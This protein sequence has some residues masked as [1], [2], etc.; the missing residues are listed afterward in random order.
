MSSDLDIRRTIEAGKRNLEAK[1]L[2]H[3][4]CRHA[5]VEKFGGTG[6]IEME[7]GLPI[8][9]HSMACD[10]APTSG[11]ATWFLEE[12][13]VY[14]HDANC[15][16]CTKR[17]PVALPNISKLIAQRDHDAELAKAHAEEEK[18]KIEA[19]FRERSKIRADIRA[20]SSVPATTFLDDLEAFDAERTV[21]NGHRLIESARLA[22]EMLTLEL[23]EHLFALLESG[24]HWFDE[25]GLTILSKHPFDQ[26]RLTHCAMQCLATGNVLHLAAE[27]V[28]E[29]MSDVS[30]SDVRNA[31]GGLAYVA[32]PP[33][34]EFPHHE[35]EKEN[36][37]P[38]TLIAAKFPED[39]AQGIDDLL[40]RRD[41]F[42][43]R[44]GARALSLLIST[45]TG[46]QEKFLRPLAALL[47]RADVLIDLERDSELRHVAH[48]LTRAIAQMFVATPM[49]ADSE[50]MRQF[51]SA[52]SE[53]EGRLAGVY[54]HVVR[55]ASG[56]RGKGIEIKSFEPYKVALT[57]LIALAESSENAD[58]I[59]HL[60]ST[61]RDPPFSLG[62]LA[63]E[64]MDIFLGAAAL[65][66]SKLEAPSDKSVIV[67]PVNP[68]AAME[69]ET[70]RSNLRYLRRSFVAWAVHGACFDVDGLA[71]F[72]SFLSRREALSDSLEA[73]I[74][75][76]ISPLLETGAGLRAMLPYLY[77]AM[78]GPSTLAR[79]AA[80]KALEELGNRRFLELP[81]LVPEALSL[82]LM[83]PY[84][85]VHK[86]AVRALRRITLPKS[87]DGHVATAL[88]TLIAVYRGG[89]DQDFLLDCIEAYGSSKRSDPRFLSVHGKILVAV[90]GEVQPSR[91]LRSGHR[92]FLKSLSTVD[93]YAD[94]VLGLFAHC[95]EDYETE[96]ALE[97]VEDLPQGAAHSHLPSVL[98]AVACDPADARICDTF[99]EILTRD[100]EWQSAVEVAKLQF[101]AIAETPRERS[102][103][104]H[105]QQLHL[106]AQFELLV[107]LGKMEEA[108]AVGDTWADAAKEIAEIREQYETS[109]PFRPIL[110]SH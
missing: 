6:L 43:L 22:P 2:I 66:D 34:P 8:G 86:A 79:A 20:A 7:T 31:V 84:V 37:S 11:M 87:F 50:L 75:Q 100:G 52:S 105:A 73:S 102:R 38:L 40:K 10:Y 65:L 70:R 46:W 35:P 96:H 25:V 17:E 109:H 36:P 4:W 94:L 57:R 68:L 30:A 80:A 103:K 48:D 33:R 41:P 47:S 1:Q 98:K 74:I 26:A 89:D 107:S 81:S 72:E 14:F 106:R 12:S 42:P 91:L 92:Y 21:G 24:E 15:V 93:G 95:R 67:A 23:T 29:R 76:E 18:R 61:L 5:R 108:F 56:E 9:H 32:S 90:L 77:S 44:L 104:L 69:Q 60:M 3:N 58:V 19:A 13:A 64:M 110:R 45:G 101:D 59:H 97:L 99:V 51:E 78:V 71:A 39:M 28:S 88:Q 55:R 27:I 82:M 16:G 53:G 62:P 49:L 54:E 85:I 63:K 83:D